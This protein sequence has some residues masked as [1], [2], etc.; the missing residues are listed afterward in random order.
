MRAEVLDTNFPSRE[1]GWRAFWKGGI[2][3]KMRSSPQFGI[4][5]VAYEL[6]QRMLF[7]DFGGSRWVQA[8]LLQPL[9]LSAGHLGLR[10]RRRQVWRFQATRIMW[11]AL[12]LR[13]DSHSLNFKFSFKA[14]IWWAGVKI[15]PR[16]SKVGFN[17]K[18]CLSINIYFVSEIYILHIWGDGDYMVDPIIELG[19]IFWLNLCF[20]PM[21][22]FLVFWELK[23][24]SQ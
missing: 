3:R 4:T 15:W 20:L 5:L 22:T 12:P 14:N 1:E 16:L 9:N 6:V 21:C 13:G 8:S 7:V 2:A 10:E 24:R 17:I 18:S 19:R 11:V 23:T